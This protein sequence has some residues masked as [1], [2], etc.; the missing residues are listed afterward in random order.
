MRLSSKLT[1]MFGGGTVAIALA[2]AMGQGLS[3]QAIGIYQTE[4]RQAT[5]H[6]HD[7]AE[8]RSAFQTQVQ[9]WKNILLRG[10]H[11]EQLDKYWHGFEASEKRVAELS[12]ALV[13]K[14]PPGVSRDLVTR[15]AQAHERMGQSYRRG[16]EVFKSQRFDSAAGDA[17]VKGMDRDPVALLGQAIEAIVADEVRIA[18]QADQAAQRAVVLMAAFVLISLAGMLAAVAW[19]V[20]RAMRPL[21][22]ASELTRRIADGDLST[23][24]APTGEDEITDLLRALEAMQSS[25]TR[26][27]GTVRNN[28]E[29]VAAASA[30]IAQGNQDLSQRT[31]EQ[32]SA[33][34]ETAASMQELESTVKQNAE[35]ALRADQLAQGATA[36]AGQGGEVVAEVVDTMKGINESSRKI[37]DIIGVIDGI[38]FQTNILAL[39]AAVEAARAGE[40]GRGFAVVASEVRSLAQ[41][42]AEAA[43]EIRALITHSVGQVEKGAALVDKAGATM[44]EIV[45]SIKRVSDLVGDISSASTEQTAGLAQVGQAVS[46]M[47]R[48]TQ[49]NAALVEQSAGAASSLKEQAQG[50]VQSVG[51]FKLSPAESA[52]RAE[53]AEWK[54]TERRGLKRAKN[55]IRPA[56]S[57]QSPF[58]VGGCAASSSEAEPDETLST[59][60]AA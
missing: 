56:F 46:Q 43:K 15:F 42:S 31:E 8:V 44:S 4:V 12:V 27:V 10:S 17:T 48:A 23:A 19:L 51:V 37:A 47:D 53:Q 6:A 26:L 33:L 28:A 1:L 14:L 40:Q 3:Y 57:K 35:N 30:Q 9:E 50:L 39:N 13:A 52:A 2:A 5:A 29:S 22:H 18:A 36:V 20:R 45:T 54:G 58:K 32:A 34:E 24:I 55:V 25:L 16:L 38:A 21:R 49:Q 7:V 60:S 59:S 11:P 41:R